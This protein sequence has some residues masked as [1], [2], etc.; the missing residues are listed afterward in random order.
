MRYTLKL[1]PCI[2]LKWT[3]NFSMILLRAFSRGFLFLKAEDLLLHWRWFSI[4]IDPLCSCP[5]S[6]ARFRR[7]HGLVALPSS[8]CRSSVMGERTCHKILS[9]NS[10]GSYRTR[11]K[12]WSLNFWIFLFLMSG[13]G[14]SWL[15]IWVSGK[16]FFVL[17]KEWRPCSMSWWRAA[18]SLI[19]I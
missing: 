16:S 13:V 4:R 5:S 17:L 14:S 12:G 7:E 3:M 10:L 11:V 15:G 18:V 1:H 2:I 6:I 8:T 19:L 9:W